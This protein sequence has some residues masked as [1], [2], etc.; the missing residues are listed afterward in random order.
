MT[1]Y[2]VIP[3]LILV[4]ILQTS[5]VPH[6]ALWGVFPDLPL[7]VVVAWSLLRGPRE[8]IIWGFIA[9]LAVD[10]LSGAPLGAATLALMLTGIL[11]GLGATTTVR[12]LLALPLLAAFAGTIVYDLVFLLMIRISGQTVAWLGT[13]VRI[14]LPSAVLNT[15]LM[16]LVFW[17]MR[18]LHIRFRPA[19]MEV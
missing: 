2:L 12:A 8:G 19:E 16:L 5:L 14:I 6:L 7:L 10:M 1:I 15:A 9:G 4:A 11:A 13:L 3:L 17:P 18:K